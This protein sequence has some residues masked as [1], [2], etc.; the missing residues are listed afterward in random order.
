MSANPWVSE[1]E[2]PEAPEAVIEEVAPPPSWQITGHPFP[3]LPVVDG[4]D[5]VVARGSTHWVT[6]AHGG[7]GTSTLA[8]LLNWGDAERSWPVPAAGGEP[9]TVWVVARTNASGMRAAQTA[10]V[11]WASGNVPGVRL[12]GVIWNADSPKKLSRALRELRPHVSG[13]FPS[14]VVLPWV[15]RWRIDEEVEAS[16]APHKVRRALKPLTVTERKTK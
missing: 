14:Q 15:E 16:A 12:G 8:R 13:A 11:H 5:L 3:D 4:L 9:L 6:G 7:A 10:A 1:P 2:V